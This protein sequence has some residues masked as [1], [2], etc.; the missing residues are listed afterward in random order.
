MPQAEARLSGYASEQAGLQSLVADLGRRRAEL[1]AQL[2]EQAD[3]QQ[4]AAHAARRLQRAVR[5]RAGLDPDDPSAQA[6]AER[7]VALAEVRETNRSMLQ[8]VQN[9]SLQFPELNIAAA[10]E[11]SGVKLP[12]APTSL[13]GSRASSRAA[14]VR[15]GGS[16]RSTTSSRGGAVRV[17]TI[18]F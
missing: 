4:R 9:L 6:P 3:K 15:S 17:A 13:A 1:E 18:G 11:A 7:D 8:E 10:F 12:S 14:S 2:R 5:A 16:V